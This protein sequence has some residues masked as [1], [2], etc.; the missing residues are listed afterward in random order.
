LKEKELM[1]KKYRIG[2]EPQDGKG[3]QKMDKKEGAHKVEATDKP[4]TQV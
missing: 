2:K 3:A 1:I 4:K